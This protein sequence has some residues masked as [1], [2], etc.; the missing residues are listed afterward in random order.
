MLPVLIVIG[1]VVVIGAYAF[2]EWQESQEEK[3]LV[4]EVEE[5]KKKPSI[6]GYTNNRVLHSQKQKLIQNWF[7]DVTYTE[8]EVK[9]I[10]DGKD[11]YLDLEVSDQEPLKLGG[12]LVDDNGE[13]INAVDLVKTRVDQPT[14][15]NE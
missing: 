7:V 1:F 14:V 3:K 6:W 10:D 9:D 13:I 12:V 8:L 4:Q 2:F 5:L 15:S 11:D